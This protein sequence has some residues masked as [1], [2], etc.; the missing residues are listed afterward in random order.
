[1][2]YI[3]VNIFETESLLFRFCCKMCSFFCSDDSGAKMDGKVAAH[4]E[5]M[6][7]SRLTQVEEHI[8][9]QVDKRF[10]EIQQRMDSKLDAILALMQQKQS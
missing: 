7:E 3:K 5:A 6:V 10:E 2:F 1:M 4:I 9:Q 8:T